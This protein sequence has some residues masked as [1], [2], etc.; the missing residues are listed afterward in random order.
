MQ[1]PFG[2][3]LFNVQEPCHD[4]LQTDIQFIFRYDPSS[5]DALLEDVQQ[6]KVVNDYIFSHNPESC[7]LFVYFLTTQDIPAS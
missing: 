6:H 2:A 3:L 4:A 1:E 7:A 5:L